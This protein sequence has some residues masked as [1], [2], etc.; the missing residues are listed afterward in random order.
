MVERF[1][2]QGVE[3]FWGFPIRLKS[4]NG[5]SEYLESCFRLLQLSLLGDFNFVT[6]TLACIGC[7]KMH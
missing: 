3:M 2:V 1:G 7:G 4:M 5:A 6:S